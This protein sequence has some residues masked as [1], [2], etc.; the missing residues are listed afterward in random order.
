M[1]IIV[2]T[3]TQIATQ[4]SA[5]PPSRTAAVMTRTTRAPTIRVANFRVSGISLKSLSCNDTYKQKSIQMKL[6]SQ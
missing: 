4:A 5:K 1:G 6:S 3:D 2:K